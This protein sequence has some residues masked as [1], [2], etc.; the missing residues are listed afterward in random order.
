MLPVRT[1]RKATEAGDLGGLRELQK[2]QEP[3]SSDC[4]E[5]RTVKGQADSLQPLAFAGL[6]T[7]LGMQVFPQAEGLR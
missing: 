1:M 6:G 3:A 2:Q 7:R 5:G 4:G